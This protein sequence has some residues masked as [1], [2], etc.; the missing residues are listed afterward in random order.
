MQPISWRVLFSVA[1]VYRV[2]TNTDSCGAL[3]LVRPG[4]GPHSD[5]NKRLPSSPAICREV[6]RVIRAQIAVDGP[7]K[8]FQGPESTAKRRHA[9]A[10]S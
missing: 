2:L 8:M 7:F 6:G 4:T 10:L 3:E 1:R 9:A 5:I